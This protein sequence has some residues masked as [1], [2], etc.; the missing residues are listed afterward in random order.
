MRGFDVAD[1]RCEPT[2]DGRRAKPFT[3]KFRRLGLNGF[4]KH[5]VN[6]VRWRQIEDLYHRTLGHAPEH[7]AEFLAGMDSELRREVEQLLAQGHTPAFVEPS[8]QLTEA[9]TAGAVTRAKLGSYQIISL[10]GKGGMG[11]VFRAHDPKLG[12]DVAIKTLPAAYASE[13]EWL[14]RFRREARALGA[15]NHP[16]IAVIHG[17]DECEGV[18]Y[19]VMELVCGETLA[20]RLGSGPIAIE[21]SLRW[22]SEIASALAAAHAK[23]I[24]HRDIKPAN[25]K[26]TPEG[27]VKVLD[28]G[29]AKIKPLSSTAA[30]PDEGPTVTCVTHAGIA[31][32]TPAYMSPEQVR[33]GPIDSRSDVW[34]FGCLAFEL[35][36]GT[37]AFDGDNSADVIAAVLTAE[38]RWDALPPDVPT[39]A[40]DLIRRC[41]CKDADGRPPNIAEAQS[42]LEVALHAPASPSS[43]L[44]VDRASVA[45]MPFR[46]GGGSPEDQFLC[47]ALADAVIHRLASV[48]K[49]VVRPLASVLRYKNSEAEWTRV[50]FDL[51]VDVVVQGAIHK[52]GSKLRVLLQV[53]SVKDSML[54]HAA[55]H[56]GHVD[57]L[58]AL[59]D[60]IADS[61][62]DLFVPRESRAA[63][64]AGPPTRNPL[65]YE[66][67]LRAV[68]RLVQMSK[69]DAEMAVEMLNQVIDL[70]PN[71]ADAWGR[72]AQSYTLMGT[73]FDVDAPWLERAEQ[74]IARTLELDPIHGDALCARA[75]ILWSP[76]R[77]FQ[78]RAAL[79]ALN[80]S[81]KINPARDVARQYRAAILLHLGFYEDAERDLMQALL[82]N[83]GYVLAGL[84]RGLIAHY[85]G[86]YDSAQTCFDRVLS[87]NPGGV[88]AN[89]VSA[90]PA[91]FMGRFDVARDRLRKARQVVPAEP[92]LTAQ[93][94]LILAGEG[95]FRQAEDLADEAVA[96]PRSLT[97]THHTWHDSAGVYA[98]CGKPEKAVLQLRR[99]AEQGLPN[100]R[101]F[102]SDPHL[103]SLQSHPAFQSLATQLRRDCDKYEEEFGLVAESL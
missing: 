73:L 21:E 81:L 75:Q 16:N 45:V 31:M 97:H 49:L 91:I 77:G 46:M 40:Q 8:S 54:L 14:A 2:Y 28:F 63:E 51:S 37:R 20:E 53:H 50:A 89:L 102:Q 64:L 24:T 11:E 55:K 52:I 92:E 5:E 103:R 100:R 94:A 6:P 99:C 9:M 83:P 12:R 87:L 3:F 58:F 26:I 17:F 44:Q 43:P 48:G 4:G 65:A 61:V 82:A 27:R 80:A 79:R 1:P 88:H 90:L 74:A 29:L 86:D 67:Y 70:D 15:L 78:I 7:R 32:G 34:S 76:S 59:Q 60:R 69:F 71:F 38:P 66:L 36:S 18:H 72:L 62:S 96:C 33:G 47:V 98:L 35:L 68:D 101:L 30:R 84:S 39:L 13:R 95:N 25:I 42:T 23:G 56:D 19:L 10:V 22:C 41:L 57:D 93:E 85:R